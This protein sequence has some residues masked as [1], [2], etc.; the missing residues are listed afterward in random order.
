MAERIGQQLGNYTIIRLIG[1]GG[2][3]EVYLGEH[4]YLKSQA[5]I[6][7]LQT[8]LSDTD[9]T[10]SFLKEAQ[11]VAR[12]AH[13]NIIRVLDFGL[14]GKT[15]FLVMDYA[16]NGTLRQRHNKG[17]PVPLTTI[18]SYTRQ[19]ADALQYAHDEHLIHRDVKPENMLIGRRNEILLSDFGIAVVAQSSRSQRTQ[20]V[21]GTVAYMAPEQIQGKPRPASDQYSLGIVVYEWLTGERPFHGSFTELCTQHVF[22]QPPLIH[23][24]LPLVSSDVERVIM[25]ALAKDPRQR[26]ESV[27]AFA[28]ALEQVSQGK[29]LLPEMLQSTSDYKTELAATS[30]QTELMQPSGLINSGTPPIPGATPAPLAGSGPTTTSAG[31]SAQAANATTPQQTPPIMPTFHSQQTQAQTQFQAQS[32]VPS[33][34]IQTPQQ[35]TGNPRFQTPPAAPTQRTTP[36]TPQQQPGG[37][38]PPYQQQQFAQNTPYR[39]QAPASQQPGRNTPYQ[40]QGPMPQQQPGQLGSTSPYQ[41]P[42][43]QAPQHYPANAPF[44]APATPAAQQ[45]GNNA[46]FQQ[47]TPAAQPQQSGRRPAEAPVDDNAYKPRAE[48]QPSQPRHQDSPAENGSSDWG[49]LDTAK[50]PILQTVVGIILFCILYNFYPAFYLN[51]LFNRNI[52]L[53]LVVP[54]F[55][56][57]AFGP[58]V[59][60]LV[61]ICGALACGLLYPG[62]D[63]FFIPLTAQARVAADWW[64]FL[65]VSTV[66]GLMTGLTMIRKRRYPTIGSVTRAS[67]LAIIGLAA[68]IG[69]LLYRWHDLRFFQPIGVVALANVVVAF[70][71]LAVYS[72]MARLIDTNS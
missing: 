18:V 11:T 23:E 14:D 68:S 50:W 49:F 63:P 40:P 48:A 26:F 67:I 71:I 65:L 37:G 62:Q 57:A 20:D 42:S 2:F 5:A 30:Y 33:S 19:I 17:I 12:L 36:Q 47:Q 29:P 58:W 43:G 9:D 61:G 70:I 69:F 55:F 51:H 66:A 3:A 22:A 6:K 28:D 59:G 4:L 53:I 60:L 16:P 27:K 64:S 54:L 1:E 52:S 44:S 13:P 25:K 31:S 10:D 24:K 7:V 45:F 72:I 32:G 38:T 34:P 46:P 41:N 15:P 8:Q 39:P 21:I 56:G 35:F